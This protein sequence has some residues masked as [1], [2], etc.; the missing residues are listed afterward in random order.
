MNLN[1][2]LN[3]SGSP[4]SSA[5]RGGS[6]GASAAA[7]RGNGDDSDDESVVGAKRKRAVVSRRSESSG[8][9][10]DGSV[11]PSSVGDNDSN[12][13]GGVSGGLFPSFPSCSR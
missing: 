8:P 6:R 2:S 7:K 9:S 10:R 1:A 5:G 4:S 3:D 12:R 11:D 13:G